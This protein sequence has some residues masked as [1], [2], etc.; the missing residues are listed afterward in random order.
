MS[1]YTGVTNF[2]KQFGFL[3]QLVYLKDFKRAMHSLEQI[4]R[5]CH[6]VRP[7]VCLGRAC[8]VI[9]RCI[10]A[11]ILVYGWIVQCSGHPDTKARPPN[12]SRLFPVHLEER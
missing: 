7:S 1:T 10:L 12:P 2:Q 11:K 5:Y 6:D 4:T 3:A 9:T 8:I